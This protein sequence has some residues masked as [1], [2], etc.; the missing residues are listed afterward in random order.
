MPGVNSETTIHGLAELEQALKDLPVELEDKITGE[1]LAAGSEVIRIGTIRRMPKRSGQ[2]ANSIVVEVQ[3]QEGKKV[4]GAAAI[5]PT[6]KRQ[7][8]VRFLEFGTKAHPIPKKRSK[9]KTKKLSFGGKAYAK[10][11][12]PGTAP[13][14]PLTVALAE[15]GEKAV[16][17]FAE[18]AWVGIETFAKKANPGDQT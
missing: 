7:H 2:T 1:A 3:N 12:H 9:K 13:R 18:T 17:A 6:G 4:G 11:N 14:A 8:V 5:G 15:D 16:K 10:V